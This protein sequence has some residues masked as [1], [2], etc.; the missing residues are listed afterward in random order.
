MF[1]FGD[2]SESYYG[3]QWASLMHRELEQWI[4]EKKEVEAVPQD[5]S[6]APVAPPTED[7]VSLKPVVSGIT[8]LLQITPDWSP[9]QSDEEQTSLQSVARSLREEGAAN[10]DGE[11]ASTQQGDINS[12][13]TTGGVE[14]SPSESVEPES[15]EPTPS[16]T[17][18]VEPSPSGGAEPTSTE[19]VEPTSTGGVEPPPSERVEPTSS[20]GVELTS[21][22]SS[23][24]RRAELNWKDMNTLKRRFT[25]D[26]LPKVTCEVEM[27]LT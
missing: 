26:I 17:G 1:T 3:E 22:S 10:G 15:V 14:P 12:T 7:W 11:V 24:N 8:N 9:R 6:D 27:A 18:S 23:T 2:C 20:V 25:Y 5:V 16:G 13:P 19:G 4:D 21:Q